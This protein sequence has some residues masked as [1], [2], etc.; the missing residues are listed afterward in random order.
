MTGFANPS[1]DLA[2]LPLPTLVPVDFALIYADRISRFAQEA[3]DAGFSYTVGTLHANL[4]ARVE[5][6][7]AYREVLLRQEFNDYGRQNLV[8]YAVG[9]NLDQLGANVGR[10]RFDGESDDDFRDRVTGALELPSTAGSE[11]GYIEAARNAASG[12]AADFAVRASGGP[13]VEIWLLPKDGADEVALAASVQ[14]GVSA[15]DVRPMNDR[16]VALIAGRRDYT[17]VAELA[18]YPGYGAADVIARSEVGARAYAAEH[19]RLAHDITVTGVTAALTVAGVRD[20]NLVLPTADIVLDVDTAS[21]LTAVTLTVA[22][23]RD[24]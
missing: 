13:L 18:L 23:I 14:A 20:V 1:I 17:V 11:R 12:M 16:P 15:E 10:V 7:D 4:P 24:V 9:S 3:A 21:R 19:E 5:R 2:A 8:A 22:P 6:T